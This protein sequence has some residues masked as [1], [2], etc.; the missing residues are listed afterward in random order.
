MR[1][2]LILFSFL[3][4]PLSSPAQQAPPAGAA[5]ASSAEIGAQE[6]E[7]WRETLLEAR[8][9][10][11]VARQQVTVTQEAFRDARKRKRRGDERGELLAAM[12]AAEQE[13]ADAEAELPAL[14]EKARREG[15]PPG[16][17]RE[18]ED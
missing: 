16:V 1:L 2:A 8:E 4:F 9:R 13:F 7:E 15:V 10:V 14:L 11:D 5:P 18:F 17:L 12:K 3:I 6:I